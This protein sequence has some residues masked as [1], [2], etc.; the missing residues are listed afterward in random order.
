MMLARPDL[1]FVKPSVDD[2][3]VAFLCGTLVHPPRRA[4]VASKANGFIIMITSLRTLSAKSAKFHIDQTH[5]KADFLMYN[6]RR[7]ILDFTVNFN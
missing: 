7:C 1:P 5:L 4:S 2:S 6:C 3:V